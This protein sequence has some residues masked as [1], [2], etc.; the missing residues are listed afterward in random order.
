MYAPYPHY[1]I[2]IHR[3]CFLVGTHCLDTVVIKTWSCQ[4]S[5]QTLTGRVCI[6]LNSL[7][8]KFKVLTCL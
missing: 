5:Q 4:T 8:A 6:E 2:M 7:N 1:K 3:H